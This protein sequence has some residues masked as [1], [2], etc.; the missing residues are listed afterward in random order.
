MFQPLPDLRDHPYIFITIIVL[1]ALLIVLLVFL[2][3][4]SSRR[5]RSYRRKV[6]DF[7]ETISVMSD[8][9]NYETA[10]DID[11]VPSAKTCDKCL[12]FVSRLDQIVRLP[13]GHGF[14]RNCIRADFRWC[15]VCLVVVPD[16]VKKSLQENH[17]TFASDCMHCE[18]GSRGSPNSQCFFCRRSIL[19][20]TYA[21]C[22]AFF[23]CRTQL[24]IDRSCI[25]SLTNQ[26]R[27]VHILSS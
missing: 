2:R 11:R 9:V 17:G 23:V 4:N 25:R 6:G 7:S 1:A 26:S 12:H 16:A 13:C 21:S 24:A 3:L 20:I 22:V 10:S 27:H 19:P 15:P 14:H 18:N 8:V 5:G